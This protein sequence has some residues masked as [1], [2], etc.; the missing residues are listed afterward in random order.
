[1]QM[2]V[3]FYFFIFLLF[4]FIHCNPFNF[5]HRLKVGIDVDKEYKGDIYVGIWREE[6]TKEAVDNFM[7]LCLCYSNI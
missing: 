6:T 7:A 3:S 5:T 2:I 4:T 1:M